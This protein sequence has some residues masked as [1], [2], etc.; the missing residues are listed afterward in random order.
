[1]A[2]DARYKKWEAWVLI[3][4]QII[5]PADHYLFSLS[6]SLLL[7][8]SIRLSRDVAELVP[9]IDVLWFDLRHAAGA[10]LYIHPGLQVTRIFPC[11]ILDGRDRRYSHVRRNGCLADRRERNNRRNS[12]TGLDLAIR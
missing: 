8:C 12:R 10:I 1:M 2:C 11:R 5:R 3:N 7:C 4:R 9:F 6:I